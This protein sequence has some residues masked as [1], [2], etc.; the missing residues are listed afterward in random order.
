MAVAHPMR[1]DWPARHPSPKKICRA[2]Y[3][4]CGFLAGLG[5]HRKLYPAFLNIKQR[6]ARRAL[7]VDFLLPSNAHNFPALADSGKELRH[8]EIALDV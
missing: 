5:N 3:G 7:R 8:V 6:I 4:D 2:Q 1:R